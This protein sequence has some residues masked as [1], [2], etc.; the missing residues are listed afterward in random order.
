MRLDSDRR[1]LLCGDSQ[2]TTNSRPAQHQADLREYIK[3]VG[4]GVSACK[5][6]G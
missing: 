5:I 4:S 2:Y 1:V 3:V 6:S